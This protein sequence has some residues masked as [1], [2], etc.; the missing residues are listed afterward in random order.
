[1]PGRYDLSSFSSASL[2]DFLFQ[3]TE[4]LRDEQLLI[5]I[6]L[7]PYLYLHPWL[8]LSVSCC[9]F[10]FLGMLLLF[11]SSSLFSLIFLFCITFLRR[12]EQLCLPYACAFLFTDRGNPNSNVLLARLNC[13]VDSSCKIFDTNPIRTNCFLCYWLRLWM[14]VSHSLTWPVMVT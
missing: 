2:V 10:V 7:F 14:P 1:M 11:S 9:L 4:P 3:K 12:L 8:P 13:S 5:V 6:W